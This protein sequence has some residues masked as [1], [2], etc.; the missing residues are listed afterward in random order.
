M[1]GQAT[2][3]RVGRNSPQPADPP[4]PPLEGEPIAEEKAA[5]AQLKAFGRTM[6]GY[7]SIQ[8]TRPQMLGYGLVDSPA[9]QAT[10]IYEK[11]AEWTDSDRNPESVISRDA[12]LDDIMLYWLAATAASSARLYAETTAE[13]ISRQVLDIPVGVSV[14]P[15]EIYLPPRIWGERT[16]SKL[17]YWNRAAR[18]GHFAAFEQPALFTSE[19]RARFAFIR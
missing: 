7:G 11:F 4:A 6:S 2:A 1:A 17:F 18:G 5:I 8:S 12:M 13:H 19:L 16:Y 15:G 3:R 9:G 10:W 14:F